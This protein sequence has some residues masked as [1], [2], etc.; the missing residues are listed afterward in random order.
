MKLLVE[1]VLAYDMMAPFT[2]LDQ[3][4]EYSLKIEYFWGDNSD[5][6]VNLFKH[7]YKISLKQA[8]SQAI[9]FQID[10]YDHCVYDEDIVSGGWMLEF[11]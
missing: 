5:T 4:Y 11:L 6:G 1:R 10:L 3:L 7:W 8:E 2:C 9:M